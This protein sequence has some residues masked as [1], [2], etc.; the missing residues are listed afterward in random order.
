[1]LKRKSWKRM[2]RRDSLINFLWILEEAKFSSQF[3]TWNTHRQSS[4]V[5]QSVQKERLSWL[6]KVQFDKSAKWPPLSLKW[7]V[8]IERERRRNASRSV[9]ACT[10]CHRSTI[11]SKPRYVK[12]LFGKTYQAMIN[13]D[14]IPTG[15]VYNEVWLFFFQLHNKYFRAK[16]ATAEKSNALKFHDVVRNR[17]DELVDQAEEGQSFRWR[18]SAN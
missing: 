5:S 17:L 8:Q 14:S 2:R 7:L 3:G 1:M 16:K 6:C 13:W 11:I 4:R 15:V 18:E 12:F 10:T 9:N